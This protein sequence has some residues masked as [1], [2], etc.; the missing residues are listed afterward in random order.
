MASK[1]LIKL[2]L[3][4]SLKGDLGGSLNSALFQ[5]ICE[6]AIEYRKTLEALEWSVIADFGNNLRCPMCK[7]LK[8]EGHKNDC[9]LALALK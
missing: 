1:Q 6:T 8:T 5:D 7:E 9:K 2:S 3:N 4:K